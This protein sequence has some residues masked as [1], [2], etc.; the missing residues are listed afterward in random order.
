MLLGK[1]QKTTQESHVQ[2]LEVSFD[3]IIECYSCIRQQMEAAREKL[4]EPPRV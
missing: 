4:F 3:D 2:D 1:M